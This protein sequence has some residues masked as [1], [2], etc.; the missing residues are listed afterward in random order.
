MAMK[1]RVSG[2]YMSTPPP[3]FGP[4]AGVTLVSTADQTD[5]DALFATRPVTTGTDWMRSSI[6]KSIQAKVALAGHCQELHDH[7]STLL[8]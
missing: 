3:S 6:Q 4:A 8:S 5:P 1:D 7:T 2:T